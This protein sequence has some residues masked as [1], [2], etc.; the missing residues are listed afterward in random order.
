MLYL[1]YRGYLIP[2]ENDQVY[3]ECP[4]CGKIHQVDLDGL[5]DALAGDR[6]TQAK[7]LCRECA[8]DVKRRLQD[9]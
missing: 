6:L 8:I 7:V 5:C 9:G 2:I 4:E 3:A 1:R